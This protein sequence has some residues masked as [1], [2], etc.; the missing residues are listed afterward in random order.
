MYIL[1]MY[2]LTSGFWFCWLGW[3]DLVNHAKST[4]EWPS[5][6]FG[7]RETLNW[8]IQYPLI[9]YWRLHVHVQHFRLHSFLTP[10]ALGASCIM[11]CVSE[12]MRIAQLPLHFSNPHLQPSTGRLALLRTSVGC[13]LLI[14]RSSKT[15]LASRTTSVENYMS[16]NQGYSHEAERK[17]QVSYKYDEN[18]SRLEKSLVSRH[19][20]GGV[21]CL[22]NSNEPKIRLQSSQEHI[23]TCNFV[24]R[25][26]P[27]STCSL[28]IL[29]FYGS[30]ASAH[31]P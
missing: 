2:I 12:C 1:Y 21:C 8:T 6:Y 29:S 20:F 31:P 19:Q 9:G 23:R 5:G 11:I 3:S 16:C 7:Y 4:T 22:C 15:A 18:K 10:W 14:L 30:L 28:T 13:L 27:S 17:H 25:V 26:R 24:D